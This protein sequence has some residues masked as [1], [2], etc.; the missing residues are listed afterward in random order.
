MR[1]RRQWL[2][3][4]GSVTSHHSAFADPT[5][6][7]MGGIEDPASEL[8]HFRA[9]TNARKFRERGRRALD[10]VMIEIQ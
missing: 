10:S 9:A 1:L 2:T 4:V 8:H 7:S 3:R 5:V 6:E